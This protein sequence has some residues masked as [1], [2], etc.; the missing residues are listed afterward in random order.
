[1][2]EGDTIFRA[3]QALHRALAGRTVTR[4]ESVLPALTRVDEDRP[5]AGRTI[6]SVTARGKH[7]LIAL[8]G[9]LVLRTHMR[10][11][12]SWHLYRPGERW[13]RAARDMRLVIETDA[14]VAVGFNVPVAEFIAGADLRRHRELIALGPDLLAAD[15][16]GEAAVERLR[17]HGDDAIGEALLNQRVVAGVGNIY[18]SETLFACGIDP[19]AAIADLDVGD[20]ARIV[21]TARALLAASASGQGRATGVRGRYVYGRAGQPCRRCGTRIRAKKTGPD[22]RITFWCP[23]C[24]GRRADRA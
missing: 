7:L 3:A 9:G 18:K 14:F 1:M 13:Q 20:L 4:F 17:A 21:A 22:A 19:A 2:P 23:R 12:G 8:S 16:D 24:Q 10:M 15:F 6:E 5:I 11:S